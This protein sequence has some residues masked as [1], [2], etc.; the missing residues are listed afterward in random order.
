MRQTEDDVERPYLTRAGVALLARR[1]CDRRGSST[2]P[3]EPPGG[4]QVD[5]RRCGYFHAGTVRAEVLT[6]G[7]IHRFPEICRPVPVA[8][9]FGLLGG[10]AGAGEVAIPQARS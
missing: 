5:A 3:A 4:G 10:V 7:R 2:R 9:P 6:D 8:P 1:W